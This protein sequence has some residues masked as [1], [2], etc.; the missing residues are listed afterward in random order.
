MH[1]LSPALL[2][3]SPVGEGVQ[4]GAEDHVLPHAVLDC[5]FDGVLCESGSH[6]EGQA[7]ALPRCL[8]QLIR[9]VGPQRGPA[10]PAN[11]SAR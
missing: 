3:G 5:I 8:G 2:Y 11:A 1:G 9:E 4:T 7:E 10:S 6:S